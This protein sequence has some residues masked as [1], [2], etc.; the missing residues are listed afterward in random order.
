[1]IDFQIK[2]LHHIPPNKTTL[3]LTACLEFNNKILTL[4]YLNEWGFV[5]NFLG[6]NHYHRFDPYCLYLLFNTSKERLNNWYEFYQ[7]Y[8]REK[9]YSFD[10]DL[11]YGTILIGFRLPHQY[12]NFPKYLM[13][14]RYS[15]M[16]T[17]YEKKFLIPSQGKIEQKKQYKVIARTEEYRKEL[18]KEL[19]VSLIG[20]E[21]EEKPKKEEEYIQ[22]GL[23]KK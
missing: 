7:V 12:K 15:K 6:I 18:E 20:M 14:G 9:L 3:Y 13:E 10:E 1:M 22:M 5:G 11:A 4:A 23:F 16:C 8:S 2:N 17:G 19:N 21:L